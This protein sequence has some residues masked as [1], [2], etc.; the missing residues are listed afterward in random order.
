MVI[1]C[2]VVVHMMRRRRLVGVC[3]PDSVGAI[4]FAVKLV[5]MHVSCGTACV[6]IRCWYLCNNTAV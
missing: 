1:I 2:Q 6:T 5:M 3:V 4:P